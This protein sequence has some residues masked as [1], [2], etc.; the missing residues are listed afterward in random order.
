MRKQKNEGK[1]KNLKKAHALALNK[2]PIFT[3][4]FAENVDG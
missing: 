1:N 2:R 3:F 4:G